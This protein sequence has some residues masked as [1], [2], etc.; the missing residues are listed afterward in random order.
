MKKVDSDHLKEEL[1]STI[2]LLESLLPIFQQY[3]QHYE[4]PK[5]LT[6]LVEKQASSLTKWVSKLS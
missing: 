1:Q 2:Q 4:L 3:Q 5:G 6:E